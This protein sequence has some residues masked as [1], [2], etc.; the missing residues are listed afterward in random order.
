MKKMIPVKDFDAYFEPL[1]EI[2]RSALEALRQIIRS[3]APK[4]K[5]VISYGIPVFKYEGSLVGLGAAKNHCAFYVMSTAVMEAFREEIAPYDTATATI[6]FSPKEP[7]PKALVE[8]IVMAR[9]V[10]N[11]AVAAARKAKK[12]KVSK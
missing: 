9:V 6:R 12:V 8:K 11:E 4:A 5:E 1:S 10:E 7:L 3:K 2:E